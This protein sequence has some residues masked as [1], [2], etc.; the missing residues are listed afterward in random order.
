MA[1]LDVRG[2]SARQAWSVRYSEG[3]EWLGARWRREICGWGR[4]CETDSV[5]QVG[6]HSSGRDTQVES[7]GAWCA[8]RTHATHV[9]S[10]SPSQCR[11]SCVAVWATNNKKPS[12]Q[13]HWLSERKRFMIFFLALHPISTRDA[14][15]FQWQPNRVLCACQAL[16][17]TGSHLMQKKKK[18]L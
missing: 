7:A 8:S 1:P 14:F 13:S 2:V 15:F 10:W 12:S 3:G 17:K 11:S 18:G 5:S 9:G 4:C 6:D 16:L